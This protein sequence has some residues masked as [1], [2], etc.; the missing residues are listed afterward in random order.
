MTLKIRLQL[1]NGV[2]KQGSQPDDF[3][4]QGKDVLLQVPSP[5]KNLLIGLKCKVIQNCLGSQ[6]GYRY[7]DRKDTSI[8][9]KMAS[10]DAKAEY[11][12]CTCGNA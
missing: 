12:I 2:S 10:L 4:H 6:T 3:I 8:Q 5:G 9:P 7:S 1:K 11:A